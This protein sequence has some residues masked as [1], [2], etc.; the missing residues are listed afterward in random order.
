MNSPLCVPALLAFL[1]VLAMAGVII[2]HN[3]QKNRGGK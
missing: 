2:K 1:L 3:I